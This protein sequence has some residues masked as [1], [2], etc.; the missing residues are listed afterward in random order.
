MPVLD[1]R[2]AAKKVI[3]S[4]SRGHQSLGNR[5]CVQKVLTVVTLGEQPAKRPS[6]STTLVNKERQ[7]Q[8]NLK[9][10]KIKREI[11]EEIG[12]MG[13]GVYPEELPSIMEIKY[14]F[15]SRQN[16]TKKNRFYAPAH[17]MTRD[18][19]RVDFR[20]RMRLSIDL[21]D[22]LPCCHSLRV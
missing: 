2:N 10:T 4:A 14:A 12:G 6:L 22:N 15:I 5:T 17:I 9:V 7:L 8:D 11:V 3:A 20:H 1:S 16:S 13:Y 18:K 21:H 19:M